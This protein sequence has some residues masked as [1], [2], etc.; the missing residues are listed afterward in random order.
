MC[1]FSRTN[2]RQV[3]LSYSLSLAKEAGAVTVGISDKGEGVCVPM[4]WQ[5]EP[6]VHTGM[7]SKFF[8][9]GRSGSQML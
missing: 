4:R 1:I 5:P 9:P 2:L 6:A 7:G 3:I 8:L